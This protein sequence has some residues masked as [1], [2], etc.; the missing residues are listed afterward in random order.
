MGAGSEVRRRAPSGPGTHR[1]SAPGSGRRG[2]QGP[3]G[4]SD[5]L[6]H[7][8]KARATCN[9]EPLARLFK[10]DPGSVGF[11][12]RYPTVNFVPCREQGLQLNLPPVAKHSF[13]GADQWMR[14]SPEY[15]TLRS[16]RDTGERS[17]ATLLSSDTSAEADYGIPTSHSVR[18]CTGDRPPRPDP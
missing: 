5:G 8:R 6:R 12:Y 9:T 15:E 3:R 4:L 11:G 16:T 13:G 1:G 17:A 18:Q 2:D 10:P 7:S 14:A